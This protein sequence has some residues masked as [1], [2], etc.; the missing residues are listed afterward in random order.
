M[1]NNAKIG[2]NTK[3]R[4]KARANKKHC[5]NHGGERFHRSRE[6]SFYQYKSMV[7]PFFRETQNKNQSRANRTSNVPISGRYG[8]I[9]GVSPYPIGIL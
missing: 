2:L 7:W 9:T 6:K 3:P 5:L 1:G 4:A 8:Y